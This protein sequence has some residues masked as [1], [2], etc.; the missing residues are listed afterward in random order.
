[1][2][3]V[4]EALLNVDVGRSILSHCAKLDQVAVRLELLQ[5]VAV[6]MTSS[7]FTA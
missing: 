3:N 6:V 1:M 7:Y 2:L 5:W 4:D